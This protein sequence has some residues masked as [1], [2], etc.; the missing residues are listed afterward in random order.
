MAMQTVAAG[1]LN[2][3][4]RIEEKSKTKHP[5]L[6]SETIS[7]VEHAT[8]W[9]R[10]MDVLPGKAE[11]MEGDVRMLTR[12]CVVRIRYRSTV[13]ADMRI[14]LTDRSRILQIVS[15]AEVGLR[16]ALDLQCEEYSV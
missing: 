5:R 3:R 2:R 9:A 16:E 4:V 14:V 11:R 7:W 15:I 1:E 10:V 6:G 13:T 8:V 12:P